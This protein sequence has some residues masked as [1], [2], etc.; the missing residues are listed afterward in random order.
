MDSQSLTC[1]VAE[2]GRLLGIGRYLAYQ[3]AREGK[4]P[5]IRFAGR[6]VVS[7]AGITKMLEE[8]EAAAKNVRNESR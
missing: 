1:T 3:L 2:A 8:A 7:R 6:W 4:L 5:A